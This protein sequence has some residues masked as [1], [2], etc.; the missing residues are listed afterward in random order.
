MSSGRDRQRNGTQPVEDAVSEDAM[1]GELESSRIGFIGC[2]AMA[3]AL[4]GGLARMGV[5]LD[6]MEAADPAADQRQA[7]ESAVGVQTGADNDAL[8]E[9]SDLVVLCVKP[10]VVGTVLSDLSGDADLLRPLWVSI[11][12]GIPL[13]TLESGLPDGARI[14]RAM[15]NTPALVGEGATAYCANAATRPN[16]TAMA[17]ALFSAVGI[18][19]QAPEEG[20]LDAVTGLSGSG[21]AYVFLFIEALIEAG[22]Q[23]GLPE[24][25]SQQLALQTV[26]GA[27]KLAL[28][29]DRSPRTLLEQVS[30]PGGT[31]VAGLAE[32]DA[33]GL[34][35]AV[36]RAVEAA[37][38]R[39][40][41][42]S[43]KS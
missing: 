24:A 26:F 25:A 37:T 33:S 23:Q 1:K 18:T 41:E 43:S 15:P 39:C 28:H 35:D 20:L 21:P 42:L 19:W 29:D 10:T 38:R 12:A 2:G 16:E 5:A 8:V 3:S 4:A 34:R 13:A 17:E 9:R 14:I 32:L 11:A 31:T 27:A 36:A 30:S 7:F 22:I 6:N 40:R